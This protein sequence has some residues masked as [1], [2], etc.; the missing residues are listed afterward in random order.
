[1]ATTQPHESAGDTTQRQQAAL[2]TSAANVSAKPSELGPYEAKDDAYFTYYALLSH[3]AQMLQDSVRTS[4]Y[5]RAILANAQDCFK[6]K[7]VIDVGAGN[8][9]LSLFA[10]QAGA[11]RVFAIEAS[12]MVEH[13]QNLVDAS[14]LPSSTS[15]SAAKGKAAQHSRQRNAWID[16][17]IQAVHSKV[18]DVTPETLGGAKQVDTIVSECLGVLLLHERMCETFIDA[19][20]R[21]L[22]PGGTMLPSGGTISLALLE[23]RN[24]WDDT[25]N[26]ARWWETENFYGVDLSPFA[27]AAWRQAFESPVVGC[28]PS[29]FVI[30]P[31]SDYFV[32]FNSV[33][34]EE[35]ERFDIQIHFADVKQTSVVHGLAGWFDLHFLPPTVPLSDASHLAPPPPPLIPAAEAAREASQMPDEDEAMTGISSSGS[36]ATTQADRVGLAT[37]GVPSSAV[38]SSANSVYGGLLSQD[39]P[40]FEP[41]ATGPQQ[42]ALDAALAAAGIA[43][44]SSTFDPSIPLGSSSSTFMSTSP[45]E[46]ATHW[47]QVRFLLPEPLAVNKGQHVTGTLQFQANEHRSYTIRAEVRVGLPGAAMDELLV[48]RCTWR[49]QAQT[50]VWSVES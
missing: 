45:F 42:S 31:S 19:R 16:G 28:F 3:Q 30:S 46:P 23:D 1:M 48:R 8:G 5:H 49:L 13:L 17:R 14:Q 7:L 44:P 6:D 9:I 39:A 24:L 50:Y 2:K 43:H 47:Q 11:R 4:I 21:F 34:K 40:V 20:D 35:L 38:P 25:A 27:D 22:K 10:A 37:S 41:T 18:E 32:D 36:D 29:K 12:G 26:K 33:K 15:T